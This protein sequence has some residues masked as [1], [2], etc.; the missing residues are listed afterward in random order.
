MSGANWLY[1]HPTNG[2]YIT[3]N[4]GTAAGAIVTLN[5]VLQVAPPDP[6]SRCDYTATPPDVLAVDLTPAA[7]FTGYPTVVLPPG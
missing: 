4:P 6:P 5:M 1:H 2:H 3:G 7:P